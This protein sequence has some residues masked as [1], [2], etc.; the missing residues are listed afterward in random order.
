MTLSA[1]LNDEREKPLWIQLSEAHQRYT[2]DTSTHYDEVLIEV[3]QRFTEIGSLGKAD[4]GS[5]LL[6]KRL[7]ADAK[8]AKDLMNTPDQ[9]VREATAKTFL[10]AND[11]RLD[12]HEAAKEARSALGSVPG[13]T[14][15]DALASAVIVAA[16]PTRMAIYD[17]RAHHG[18]SLLKIKL[19]N[20]SGRY[21]RYMQE[22]QNLIGLFME[23]D[24]TW[25]AREIDQALF[26]IGN[27]R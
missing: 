25:T 18:L 7:R 26:T 13:F 11:G 8:W 6:W 4:I 3:S 17:R 10:A 22:V 2:A 19:T 23:H 12:I 9:D 21:S 14:T 27:Q 15:G 16:A 20:S 5:L 24:Q 1:P